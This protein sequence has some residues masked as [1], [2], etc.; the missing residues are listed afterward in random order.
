MNSD[1][2][3]TDDDFV[4]MIKGLGHIAECNCATQE[5]LRLA[6]RLIS[7]IERITTFITEEDEDWVRQNGEK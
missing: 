7:K 3:F 2:F 6:F 4:V 5:E 1:L